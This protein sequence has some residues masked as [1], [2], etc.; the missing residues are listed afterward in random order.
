MKL[1]SEMYRILGISFGVNVEEVFL[2]ICLEMNLF[3]VFFIALILV[4][5]HYI[6][7]SFYL[8]T[9]HLSIILKR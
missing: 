3:L 8:I 9:E 5:S 2:V 4:E 6:F 7:S 1:Q